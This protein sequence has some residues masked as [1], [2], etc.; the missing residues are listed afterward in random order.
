MKTA[1]HG[2]LCLLWM[3]ALL[4]HSAAVDF[5]LQL[6]YEQADSPTGPWRGVDPTEATRQADGSISVQ[7]DGQRFYRLLISQPDAK[8]PISTVRLGSLPG[9]SAKVLGTRVSELT[10]FLRPL[11]ITR[12][13]D[14]NPPSSEPLEDMAGVAAWRDASF[15]SNAIPIYDPAVADG[16]EPAYLEIKV[17]GPKPRSL[18]G[19]DGSSREAAPHRGSILMSLG[20]HDV[21]IPF[22]STEGETPAER[23]VAKLG[24]TDAVGRRI[25]T[26]PAGHKIMRYGPTFHVLEGPDGDSV[27][28]LGAQPFK[29][30]ADLLT[31][32]PGTQ[33]GGGQDGADPASNSP[34]GAREGFS[35]YRNYKEFKSDYLNNP[36][37]KELR[38][39]R[40]LRDAIEQQIEVGQIPAAPEVIRLAIGGATTILA[41]TP[42]DSFFMDDDDS[43]IDTTSF[44]S[45]TEIRGGGLRIAATK[46]GDGDLVVKAGR[47]TYKYYVTAA[48]RLIVPTLQATFTPGWQ[49]PK[50]WDAGGYDEQPRYWQEKRDRWCDSV[51]CGP[52]A[53]AILLA[54]WDQHN[55]PSAFAVGT[56]SSL[57]S[58]LRTQDAP[59]W[60]DSDYDPSGYNRVIKLYDILHDAC[61]VICD[62]F[63]DSGA[64][65]PG[66]MVEAWWT[67]T[68]YGRRTDANGNYWPPPLPIPANPC[69]TQWHSWAW[70]LSDPDWNEPSNVIR[71]ANKNGRPAIVGLGWL[72]HYGVSYA[73][74]YQEFKAAENG[75][76]LHRRRWFK[77]N[78]GW[79]KDHGVWYSGG[80]T[81]LGFDLKLKQK[82]LPPP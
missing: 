80:D 64:T 42:I 9:D 10:R 36:V 69:M 62:P 1:L 68:V 34:S 52:V 37:Y 20:R 60:F 59:F 63:S 14:T 19:I 31:R 40:A 18:S 16:L 24:L 58:S 49:D 65:A 13:S 33:R 53:W 28:S 26:P 78:E 51:G 57:R 45:I 3:G 46:S 23:L 6:K 43:D 73:Y 2:G 54:W 56:G 32:Y 74:R 4:S 75:P 7:P 81:F 8:S 15:A 35:L 27:A 61:D 70:D 21:G 77:V 39:R 76:V 82:H 72:W 25:L 44:V 5:A 71:K 38:R 17:L 41:G 47:Q 67:P 30:P 48:P 66:D 22:F 55:V 50:I 12:G 11:S 79:G 29:L